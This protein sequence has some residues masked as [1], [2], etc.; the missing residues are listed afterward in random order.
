MSHWGHVGPIDLGPLSN[1]SE[2]KG[3]EGKGRAG[4]GRGGK[5]GEG[6]G[7]EGKERAGQGREG[8]IVVH[9]NNVSLKHSHI[10]HVLR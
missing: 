9:G 10:L 4:Q 7:G 5:G 6:K 3:R 2:G 8:Y 1:L